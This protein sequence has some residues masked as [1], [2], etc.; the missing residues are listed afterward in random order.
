LCN[1]RNVKFDI[2]RYKQGQVISYLT[3]FIMS[4]NIYTNPS[5]NDNDHLVYNLNYILELY[6]LFRL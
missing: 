4:D 6:N 5:G 1:I 2:N 3:M